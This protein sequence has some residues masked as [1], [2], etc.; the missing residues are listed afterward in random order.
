[1]KK[2]YSHERRTAAMKFFFFLLITLFTITTAWGNT[3]L[4]KEP[5][6][7]KIYI[8]KSQL[9]TFYDGTYYFD[10]MGNSMKVKTISSDCNGMYL[11]VI[12]YQCP[13]CGRCWENHQADEGYDCPLFKREV[14]PGRWEKY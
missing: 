12:R 4:S 13:S 9:V 5:P 14:M 6:F 10:D 1:M 7:E 11:L 3:N 8:D 2:P